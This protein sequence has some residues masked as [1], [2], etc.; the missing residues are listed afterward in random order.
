MAD[1]TELGDRMK[2]Y[3]RREAGRRLLPSLPVCVRLDGKRFSR[4]TQGLARPYDERLS[5]LMVEVTRQLVE[6]TG[7]CV[8]Y[9]QSDEI[10]L[11][12]Y[13]GDPA[14]GVYL[15]GRVQKLTSVLASQTTALFNRLLPEFLPEK[16]GELPLFDCR[17]WAVP[18]RE[19]ACNAVLW[20]ELDATKNSISMAAQH[21][22]SHGALQGRSGSEKQ[23]LLHLKGVN[24]NDYPAFFKRG[25][26]LRRETESRR[27][28]AEELEVL[29]PR[30]AARRDP[31]LV[32]TRSLVRAV[33]M[34][35]LRRVVNRVAV[36][37]EGALPETAQE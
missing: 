2:G 20:R 4:F 9:T 14:K 26:Y 37:F 33:D 19:E 5:R 3:E 27:F 25:T 12:L 15:D 1:K 8:G 29:P 28:T 6:T 17:V 31:E 10:S 11:I 32:V 24:W 22:Y 7:A 16:V 36:L 21:Y 30:H 35:P 23:D 18:S 13:T 34:P